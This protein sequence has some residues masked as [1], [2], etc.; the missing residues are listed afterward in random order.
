MGIMN[1][2]KLIIIRRK[3]QWEKIIVSLMANG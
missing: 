3:K 2:M 1:K